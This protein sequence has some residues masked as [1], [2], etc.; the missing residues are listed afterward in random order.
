MKKKIKLLA[1]FALLICLALSAMT[2]P[3]AADYIY[4]YNLNQTIDKTVV[5]TAA[6]TISSYN[7][8]SLLPAGVSLR[9]DG[10]TL[11]ISGTAGEAGSFN[12]GVNV[13]TE[14]E[15]T[16][17]FSFTVSITAPTPTPTQPPVV[18][19]VPTATPVPN[20]A[21]KITKHPTGE[22]VEAGGTAKFIARADN[23]TSFVWRIVSADTTNTVPAADAPAY[24]SGLKV[25]GL[26]SEM[27]VLSGIPKAMNGWSVECKF[28]G[29]GGTSFTN[30][31]TI[32][33][34]TAANTGTVGNNNTT[35]ATATPTTGTVK[36]ATI[37]TQPQGA[38]AQMG[39]N[40]TLSVTAASPDGGKLSYQW[41]SSATDSRANIV[42]IPDATS[43]S[44]TPPQTEGL[45]YYCVAI[46]NS[47]NNSN[48]A[49]TYSQLVPVRYTAAVPTVTPSATFAPTTMQPSVTNAPNVPDAN[50]QDPANASDGRYSFS[51]SL[52]FFAITGVVAIIAMV[53]IIIY[54][55]KSGKD[56][57]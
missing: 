37:S 26:D 52:I 19:A 9:Q 10:L 54:I 51:A 27:L 24:F 14:S 48:S 34:T 17:S 25:S 3:A 33:V 31:A 35:A 12:C 1:V 42:S 5:Y 22:T 8:V 56:E 40:V 21:P 11:Y 49:A 32:R 53:V 2:A 15:G 46:T 30:G 45:V 57:E 50:A 41:Y 38:E 4:A 47:R 39:S 43:S 29:P 18:T 55:K 16:Q 6:S 36:A 44:Y 23:A 28:T 20:T 7:V 13:T